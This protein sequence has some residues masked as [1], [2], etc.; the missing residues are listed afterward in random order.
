M[1]L[2]NFDPRGKSFNFRL[3]RYSCYRCSTGKCSLENMNI[4][5]LQNS[6]VCVPAVGESSVEYCRGMAKLFLDGK[7][8]AP[9]GI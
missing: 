8:T 6:S 1:A 5:E 9:A 3:D 2:V 7:F 4:E